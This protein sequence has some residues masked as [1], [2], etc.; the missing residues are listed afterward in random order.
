MPANNIDFAELS[1][2]AQLA[3]RQADHARALHAWV[4]AECQLGQDSGPF[5]A[6]VRRPYVEAC[7]VAERGFQHCVGLAEDLAERTDAARR[8]YTESEREFVAALNKIASDYGW[9]TSPWVE[10]PTAALPAGGAQGSTLADSYGEPVR[11]SSPY[12]S[13]ADMTLRDDF[14][15]PA[16]VVE[17]GVLRPVESTGADAPAAEQRAADP[18]AR[19]RG[20]RILE[21]L[22]RLSDEQGRR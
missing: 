16:E 18:Q 22:A 10:P 20:A 19:Q 1:Q 4:R 5:F 2:L 13:L 8:A 21:D 6:L 17:A 9:E 11:H 14:V 3:R 15:P 12:S 7:A